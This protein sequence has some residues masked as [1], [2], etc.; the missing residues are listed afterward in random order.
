MALSMADSSF[1]F[2]IDKLMLVNPFNPA[3]YLYQNDARSLS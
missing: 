2:R 3:N 1:I